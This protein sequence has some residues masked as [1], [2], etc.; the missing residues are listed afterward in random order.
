MACG[1]SVW[2]PRRKAP[3]PSFPSCPT[4]RANLRRPIATSPRGAQ[5]VS[6]KGWVGRPRG[7]AD[8]ECVICTN[9][10]G[11]VGA[12]RSPVEHGAWPEA[13]RRAEARPHSA[14]QLAVPASTSA[15]ATVP[16]TGGGGRV[17]QKTR[18]RSC[19]DNG[20]DRPEP[21][22]ATSLHRH[23]GKAHI[24]AGRHP[25]RHNTHGATEQITHVWH[26]KG[27]HDPMRLSTELAHAREREAASEHFARSIAFIHATMLK[28]TKQD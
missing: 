17:A 13:T 15:P 25:L 26:R 16:A 8:S 27:V 11:G 4:L 28:V 3:S 22:S 24:G 23:V 12:S 21:G 20:G 7:H 19:S 5:R 9:H 1:S 18:R 2:R 6:N 10:A 14:T